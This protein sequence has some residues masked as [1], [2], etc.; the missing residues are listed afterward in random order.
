MRLFVA[1]DLDADI[2]NKIG[3]VVNRLKALGASGSFI[4]K[5]NLHLTLI[6][7][8]E[9]D[10]E[11][12]ICEAMNSAIESYDGGY[13]SLEI[14]GL[15]TFKREGGDILWAGIEAGCQLFDLQLLLKKAL[16]NLGFQMENRK[17]KP[18]LTLGRKVQLPNDTGI[19]SISPI[20]PGY[21]QRV[22]AISL[23]KSERIEGKLVYTEIYRKE[24]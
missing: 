2:K 4:Y 9:T 23:M 14:K 13:F 15:G 11:E 24:I 5:E 12:D 1:I 22:K 7:I 20:I 3:D 16:T 21:E 19:K 8:G 6:F 18:H 17:Y 10:R